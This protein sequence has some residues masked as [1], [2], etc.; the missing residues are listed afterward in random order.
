MRIIGEIPNPDCKITLF[1]W[2][3]RYLIKLEQ[4][5]LEQTYKINQF[6][7]TSENDLQKIVNT[8]FINDA[9]ARFSSMASTLQRSLE[10]L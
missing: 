4:G 8:E 6:E 3:N 9:L 1:S 7:L 2:N 10:N 5:L